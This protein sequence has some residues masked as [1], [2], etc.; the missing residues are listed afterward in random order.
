[1]QRVRR[2]EVLVL[3]RKGQAFLNLESEESLSIEENDK[4]VFQY[5]GLSSKGQV[6]L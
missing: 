6:F 1:V 2:E 5:F 4:V 3:L